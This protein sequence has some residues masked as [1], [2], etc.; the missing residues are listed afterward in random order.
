M[1]LSLALLIA[2][3]ATVLVVFWTR[4]RIHRWRGQ[5]PRCGYNVAGSVSGRCSECGLAL[6]GDEHEIARYRRSIR[7]LLPPGLAVALTLILGLFLLITLAAPTSTPAK[8]PPLPVPAHWLTDFDAKVSYLDSA[9]PTPRWKEMF[10]AMSH[11]S[12]RREDEAKLLQRCLTKLAEE[13]LLL[14]TQP[15]WPRDVDPAIELAPSNHLI[16]PWENFF[17]ATHGY[18]LEVC[19]EEGSLVWHR[20]LVNANYDEVVSWGYPWVDQ[21]FDVPRSLVDPEGILRLSV[22]IREA[23]GLDHWQPVTLG[24]VVASQEV[25][26]RIQ[27][28]DEGIEVLRA[29]ADAE[30]ADSLEE[31]IRLRPDPIVG[32]MELATPAICH[33]RDFTVALRITIEHAGEPLAESHLICDGFYGTGLSRFCEVPLTGALARLTELYASSQPLTARITGE[34]AV[35]LRDPDATAYW[36]GEVVIPLAPRQPQPPSP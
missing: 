14:R 13:G 32:Q 3:A 5:C 27:R 31:S 2:V 12:Y 21:A 15:R 30:I 33:D 22:Q 23:E 18:R 9:Y 6:V 34:Q 24:D 1:A 17:L 36:Q 11:R 7:L 35:A 25:H 8:R 29:V 19:D 10:G 20:W 26:L 28:V 4:G 16:H